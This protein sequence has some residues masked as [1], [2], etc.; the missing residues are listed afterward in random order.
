MLGRKRNDVPYVT[1][2]GLAMTQKNGVANVHPK[3]RPLTNCPY[4]MILFGTKMERYDKMRYGKVRYD[5][6]RYGTGSNYQTGSKLLNWI[7]LPLI[8]GVLRLQGTVQSKMCISGGTARAPCRD[9][10]TVMA[11]VCLHRISPTGKIQIL[12]GKVS[13]KKKGDRKK[14]GVEKKE[15]TFRQ[16]TKEEKGPNI[17]V[18]LPIAEK[19]KRKL[20]LVN[21]EARGHL[22]LTFAG[23]TCVPPAPPW[24]LAQMTLKLKLPLPE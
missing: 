23:V 17:A 13:V 1:I 11:S 3:E 14:D 15:M 20:Q 8:N 9:R 19:K 4:Y 22:S 7:E 5:K 12:S 2:T 10:C 21:L 16:V 6:M 18:R 24:W